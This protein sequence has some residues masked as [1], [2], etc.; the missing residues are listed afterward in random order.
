[1][2]MEYEYNLLLHVDSDDVK[3]LD[4]ALGNAHHFLSAFTNETIRLVIVVNGP[5]VKLMTPQYPDQVRKAAE[6]TKHPSAGRSAG[7]PG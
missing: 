4:L 3:T 7:I 1:M 5:G 2:D 6:M